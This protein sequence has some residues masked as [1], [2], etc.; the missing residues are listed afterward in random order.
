[1]GYDGEIV[2][3]SAVSNDRLRRYK[4][5]D[6]DFLTPTISVLGSSLL[7]RFTT[8]TTACARLM[9]A[10]PVALSLLRAAGVPWSPL[11]QMPC[12]RGICAKSGTCISSLEE[13]TSGKIVYDGPSA[14]VDQAVLDTIYADEAPAEE[15]V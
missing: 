2:V 8:V 7:R 14:N 6:Y 12:T 15:A 3:D 13:P 5:V 9:N 1:M 4:C 11:S 10:M